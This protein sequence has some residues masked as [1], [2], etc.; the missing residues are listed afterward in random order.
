MGKLIA[1]VG[2]SGVGK[3]TLTRRLCE[4]GSFIT[5]LEQ[6][7]ERLFQK[8]FSLDL[9]RFALANQIDYLLFRAEQEVYIRN[10]KAVGIQDGGLEEDFYI[11]TRLFHQ[12]GYLTLAEL[13][14]CERL[15]NFVR[16]FLPPP[17]VFIHLTAPIDVISERFAKRGRAFEIAKMEDLL[18]IEALI[19]DWLSNQDLGKVISVDASREGDFS[20]EDVKNLL[21][22]VGNVL[23]VD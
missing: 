22:R 12:Q 1:V 18:A 17:D 15:Y 5:G 19:N 3:T 10:H 8:Q 21:I 14:L 20:S 2:N 13:L 6:F 16:N 23:G 4:E 9:K 11:F 7:D